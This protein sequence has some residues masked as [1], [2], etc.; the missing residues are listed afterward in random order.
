MSRRL[1]LRN[2]SGGGGL[3]NEYQQ[4][5]WIGH[6]Q[7]KYSYVLIT[8]PNYWTFNLGKIVVEMT[9]PSGSTTN[10]VVFGGGYANG[11]CTSPYFDLNGAVGNCTCVPKLSDVSDKKQKT[12]Y[13]LTPK[14]GTQKSQA[15]FGYSALG[16]DSNS[17]TTSI[18]AYSIFVYDRN[19][20]VLFNGIPCYRK[21]DNVI[22]LFDAVNQA[23]FP[24]RGTWSKGADV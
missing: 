18:Q 1:M 21:S 7:N 16:W 19:D 20:N 8:Y 13:V 14:T 9:I 2:A 11:T 4:V 5:E 15:D 6:T 24:V 23:F 22:G 17:F 12:T 10:P 3:P